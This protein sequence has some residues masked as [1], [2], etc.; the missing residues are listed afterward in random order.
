VALVAPPNGNPMPWT[1]VTGFG[2]RAIKNP[3]NDQLTKIALRS[4]SMKFADNEWH[5][6]RCDY[7]LKAGTVLSVRLEPVTR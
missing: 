3:T 5:R 4:Q 7:D 6:V 2:P 1:D